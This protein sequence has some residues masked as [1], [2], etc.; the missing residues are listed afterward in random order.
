[1]TT[2]HESPATKQCLKDMLSF[3]ARRPVYLGFDAYDFGLPNARE[4]VRELVDDLV[5]L[6]LPDL[7]ICVTSGPEIGQKKDTMVDHVSSVVCSDTKI[8]R[9]RG[10]TRR[11]S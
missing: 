5:N 4:E 7:H 9:W 6:C 8:R 11:L 10:R 3:P 1:M 2:A